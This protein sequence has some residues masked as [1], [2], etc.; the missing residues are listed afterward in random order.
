M[1]RILDIVDGKV[2]INENCLLIPQLKAVVDAYIDHI[3]ALTYVA[4]MTAPDSPYANLPEDEKQQL[5]SEDTPGEFGLEDDVIIAAL[6]K[7]IKLN[8]TPTMRFY[9]AVKKSM[10]NM[11]TYLETAV[12]TGGKDGNLEA[13]HRI[14][15]NA[16]KTIEAFKKLERIK[17]EEIKTALRGKAQSGMY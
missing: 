11:S 14:Q 8:N 3:P 2:R 4:Y 1:I 12:I 5:I 9:V 6:N 17:D 7:M 15:S 16:G 10:D 13:I